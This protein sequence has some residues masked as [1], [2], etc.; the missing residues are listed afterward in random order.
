MPKSRRRNIAKPI[1][2]DEFAPIVR[3][4]MRMVAHS[5]IES[6]AI[7]TAVIA[8]TQ[9]A[10]FAEQVET[11]RD[12]VR[13]IWRPILDSLEQSTPQSLADILREFEGPIH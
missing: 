3:S 4:I 11:A 5:L 9:D 1:T 2:E 7:Q 10:S 13:E 12:A 8:Y 6:I